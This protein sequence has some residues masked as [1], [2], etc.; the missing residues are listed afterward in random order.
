MHGVRRY[1]TGTRQ[2]RP[3]TYASARSSITSTVLCDRIV[4]S[5]AGEQAAAGSCRQAGWSRPTHSTQHIRY[6]TNGRCCMP[7]LLSCWPLP[8]HAATTTHYRYYAY[9][10]VDCY[11]RAASSAHGSQQPAAAPPSHYCHCRCQA[12]PASHYCMQPATSNQQPAT[13]NQQPAHNTQHTPRSHT[14]LH[15][16]HPHTTSTAA[17][18]KHATAGTP[19]LRQPHQPQQLTLGD[20]RRVHCAVCS[21]HDMPVSRQHRGRAGT[22]R[23]N[24]L[25]P[26]APASPQP[27]TSPASNRCL[28]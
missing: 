12:G 4:D 25:V 16:T 13:S 5:C 7:S 24:T 19:A 11:E 6:R 15:C 18:Y 20:R 26:A 28:L 8:Y 17:N 21:P 22:F 2:A 1:D 27:P 10:P 9:R 14:T 23:R 3:T